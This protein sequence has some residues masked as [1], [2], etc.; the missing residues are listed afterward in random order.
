MPQPK[1]VLFLASFGT[2]I[3]RAKEVS[4]DLIQRDLEAYTHAPVWQVFTDD[5]TA[6]AVSGSGG[7]PIYTVEDAVETAVSQGFE[8]VVVVP[9]FIAKGELY[10]A[11]R[12]RLDYYRDRI[13]IH[14]TESVMFHPASCRETA[15]VL[16]SV[17]RPAP[18][19]EYILVGHGNSVY[20]NQ[21]YDLLEKLMREQ[22]H[23][24]IRV[25]RLM[26]KDSLSQAVSWLKLRG[27]AMRDAQVEIWP[28][29]VAWGD[30]M[31]GELYN[32][33]DSFMWR[34]RQA[35]FRTVFTGRGLGEYPDFRALYLHRLDEMT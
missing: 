29:V 31:A 17:I 15:Q 4:Y 35:G 1:T 14:M 23:E 27:A 6:R 20:H 11:L 9:V 10:N 22:G 34:L 30:Y 33:Q 25:I 3:L 21:G 19:R 24:N 2:S 12:T 13:D 5:D 7:Q 32:A 8:R 16:L 28:L 26:E 18:E